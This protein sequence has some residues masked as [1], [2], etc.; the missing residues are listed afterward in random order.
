MA[1]HM[2][3]RFFDSILGTD[4]GRLGNVGHL[5]RCNHLLIRKFFT[6]SKKELVH[7]CF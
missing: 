2:Q 6:R 7:D 5:K 3:S 4:E 1:L